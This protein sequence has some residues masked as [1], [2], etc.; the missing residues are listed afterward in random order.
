MDRNGDPSQ[1][2]PEVEP[3]PGPS[4]QRIA[5]VVVAV[6]LTLL[7]LWIIHAFLPA[8]AWATILA[9]AVR[10]LYRRAA[11]LAPARPSVS[12]AACHNPGSLG[13]VHDRAVGLCRCKDRPR[14]WQPFAVCRRIDPIAGCRCPPGYRISRESGRRSQIGGRQSQRSSDDKGAVWS[15]IQA[16]SDRVRRRSGSRCCIALSFFYLRCSRCFSC[17]ATAKPCVASWCGSATT[18]SARAAN[19]LPATDPQRCTV[20]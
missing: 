12:V 14:E 1:R 9:I 18:S 8:I 20:P 11:G 16:H 15:L 5:R 17:F 19:G 13:L 7:G 4:V 2:A 6:A 10:P 3:T